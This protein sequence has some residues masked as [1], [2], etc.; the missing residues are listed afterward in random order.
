MIKDPEN[1]VNY[2]NVFLRDGTQY[3]KKDI[4]TYPFGRG[5]SEG[6]VVSF[7]HENKLRVI[8]M[9]LVQYVELCE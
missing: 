8:P 1:D 4:P 6:R 3:T 5:E 7:W 9:D 2:I